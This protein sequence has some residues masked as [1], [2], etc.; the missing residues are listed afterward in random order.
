MFPLRTFALFTVILLIFAEKV[1]AQR[2]GT[3]QVGPD[4]R[5]VTIRAV[6][7]DGKSGPQGLRVELDD[8]RGMQ[9][10]ANVTDPSGEAHFGI[11][12]S[13]GNYQ[14]VITGPSILDTSF[15][16][17][18]HHR[19]GSSLQIV[20]VRPKPPGNSAPL[21]SR[22]TVSAVDLKI[23]AN[24]LKEFKRGTDAMA[25][26]DWGEA[27]KR[28]E[29]AIELYPNYVGAYNNLGVVFTKRGEAEK[30]Q[31]AFEKAVAINSNYAPGYLNLARIASSQAKYPQPEEYLKKSVSLNP[32]NP[33]ALFLLAQTE[34][35]NQHYEDAIRD[36]RAVHSLPHR[37][38][39]EAHYIC[40][41]ALQ[42]TGRPDEAREEY[43]I[44]LA[45]D[46]DAPEAGQVRQRL[47]V[48]GERSQ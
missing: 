33:E 16:F 32:G 9:L 14:V 18:V 40:A 15:S 47:Q 23:P 30:G 1:S 27:Q 4:V 48:L 42:A 8:A 11:A 36:A 38:Y 41:M 37:D 43:K 7:P 31:A 5:D 45:E 44:F 46:P 28:L 20:Q 3:P 6:L 2:P 29:K 13:E 21:A 26:Q 17:Q 22:A 39:A 10:R 35:V 24:A 25:R 12:L 34:F 19:E